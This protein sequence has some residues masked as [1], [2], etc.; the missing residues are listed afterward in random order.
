FGVEEEFVLLDDRTLVPLAAGD[1]GSLGEGPAGGSV[2][3]EYLGSQFECTTDPVGSLA[4]AGEQLRGL[5][6]MLAR[7][8]ARSDGV[9]APVGAPFA[10]VGGPDV[11]ASPH[12]DAVSAMLGQITR[13]HEVNGL[14]VHV[15]VGDDEERV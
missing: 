6:R 14:H 3:A 8:A 9:I 15:E 10:L 2:T 1:A 12:Y 4:E 5:R 7:H 13:E 11:S